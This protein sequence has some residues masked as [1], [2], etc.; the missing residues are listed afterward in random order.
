MRCCNG[1]ILWSVIQEYLFEHIDVKHID[2]K[3]I[4]VP[5]LN[6]ALLVYPKVKGEQRKQ[7]R[8]EWMKCPSGF[9]PSLVRPH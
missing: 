6:K 4:K 7:R 8:V 9:V 2:I 5:K 3:K 1:D